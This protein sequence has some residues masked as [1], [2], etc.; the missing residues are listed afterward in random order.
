MTAM[1]RLQSADAARH[2]N[3]NAT[4]RLFVLVD[5][6]TLSGGYEG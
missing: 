2:D 6:A 5:G 1:Q 3:I 4:K